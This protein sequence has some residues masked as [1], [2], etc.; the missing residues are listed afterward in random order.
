MKY[1]TILPIALLLSI[2][3]AAIYSMEL[4]KPLTTPLQAPEATAVGGATIPASNP[5]VT[6]MYLGQALQSADQKTNELQTALDTESKKKAELKA[7]LIQRLKG[8]KDLEQKLPLEINATQEQIEK[9]RKDLEAKLK[10][11]EAT[12]ANK[13]IELQK[14]A[15]TDIAK[16]EEELKKKQSAL[17]SLRAEITKTEN[18]LNNVNS[19]ASTGWFSWLTW[20]KSK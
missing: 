15:T 5:L 1:T 3:T 6:T 4:T 9:R 10:D 16:Y 18:D 8:K 19:N 14:A 17:T 7:A 12:F 13:K 20:S 2:N 11:E